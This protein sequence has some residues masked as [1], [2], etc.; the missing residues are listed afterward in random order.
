M[1]KK[2]VTEF[3]CDGCGKSNAIA[4]AEYKEY[5]ANW[6]VPDRYTTF[7]F[8]MD[9][10]DCKVSFYDT[11]FCCPKCLADYSQRMIIAA[12]KPKTDEQI[13]ELSADWAEGEIMEVA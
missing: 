7:E 4:D 11:I 6:I 8:S 10:E 12:L 13:K 1:I 9:K 5:P 3:I 2:N